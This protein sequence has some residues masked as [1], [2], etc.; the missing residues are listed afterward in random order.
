MERNIEAFGDSDIGD[1]KKLRGK[2]NEDSHFIDPDRGIFIVAD[3]LGGHQ[4]G[5]IASRTAVE[6]VGKGLIDLV[7]SEEQ[8]DIEEKIRHLI[9]EA[10]TEIYNKNIEEV[11]KTDE[12]N[13]YMGTTI[14]LA[15][16]TDDQIYMAYAGNSRIYMVKDGKVKKNE[17]TKEDAPIMLMVEK[18]LEIKDD[19][20]KISKKEGIQTY[21][22]SPYRGV[23]KR[24]LGIKD[25]IEPTVVSE[26]VEGVSRIM[27]CTDGLTDNAVEHE[28][29]TLLNEK[30]PEEAVK[31]LIYLANNPKEIEVIVQELC[32]Q[33]GKS[34]EYIDNIKQ[35]YK[36][37]DNI[38]VI[39]VRLE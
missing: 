18:A 4:K 11:G 29:I 17:L 1:K 6:Y 34:E 30:S 37:N 3:G 32:S 33:K 38:T 9:K 5:E 25:Y 8:D 7:D 36:G 22:E 20:K 10:N 26:S 13:R 35:N 19:D 12:I 21:M 28:M 39:A 16:V 15:L 23:V 2:G 24:V 27:L 14:S 31:E